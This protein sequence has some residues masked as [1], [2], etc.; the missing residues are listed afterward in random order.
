MAGEQIQKVFVRE[1]GR[2][3][4]RCEACGRVKTVRLEGIGHRLPAVRIR[5]DCAAVFPVHFEY[6][7]SFRKT[8]KF[9]GTYHVLLEQEELP[10]FSQD[11]KT[12]NCRIENLSMH[13]AGFPVL[14]R[15]GIKENSRLLLGFT[16]DNLQKT[17][18]KKTGVV[19]R[20]EGAYLG[21]QFDEP[22]GVDRDLGFYLMP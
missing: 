12:I 10:D 4:I 17:W 1:D 16:L 11:K 22:A 9:V 8:T 7:K 3:K 14:G 18:I 2:A 6:R 15:H 20:V 19:R 5:C 21:M 13:S